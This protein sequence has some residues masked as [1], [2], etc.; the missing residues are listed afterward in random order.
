MLDLRAREEGRVAGDVG[1]EEEA[2]LEGRAFGHGD[3]TRAGGSDGQRACVNE[4]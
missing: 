1:D 4:S 3:T 2:V